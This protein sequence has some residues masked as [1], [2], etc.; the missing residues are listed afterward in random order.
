MT[1]NQE[2]RGKIIKNTQKDDRSPLI[3]ILRPNCAEAADWIGQC[4]SKILCD[5]NPD[6]IPNYFFPPD[7]II[8]K[9]CYVHESELR[10]CCRRVSAVFGW[11]K[12]G[13]S[14]IF[15]SHWDK[16][17]D[18]GI[19]SRGSLFGYFVL[20]RFEI[21]ADSEVYETVIKGEKIPWIEQLC[22]EF[23]E[24]CTETIKG[25]KADVLTEN[26]RETIKKKIC[27]EFEKNWVNR[28][29][30]KLSRGESI[31]YRSHAVRAQPS[32]QKKT[33]DLVEDLFEELIEEWVISLQ[34]YNSNRKYA[35]LPLYITK[36]E[37]LRSCGHRRT[38]GSIYL[39]DDLASEI[40][41]EFMQKVAAA[42]NPVLVQD[43]ELPEKTITWGRE[44]F[45][46]TVIQV[47]NRHSNGSLT[48]IPLCSK[49]GTTIRGELALF[50]S[51]PI[52]Q[53][54]PKAYFRNVLRI[55]GGK[56]TQEICSCYGNK[57]C[58]PSIPLCGKKTKRSAQ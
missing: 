22:E 18:R 38:V 3:G 15:L 57:T 4:Y 27:E 1:E 31:T 24:V 20:K 50:E 36:L 55:D 26:N 53:R 25:L 39:V 17:K 30:R 21:I 12:P 34:N 14:R 11:M 16:Y 44:L 58:T 40:I 47:K 29:L 10:G 13:K 45:K 7:E 46:E 48:R 32:A 49:G 28:F 35:L 51:Y 5:K 37:A 52:F 54:K 2:L 43:E 6:L 19:R 41:D 23:I 9:S 33:K 8:P 42:N 56:F